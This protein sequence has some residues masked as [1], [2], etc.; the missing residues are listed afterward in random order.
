[1]SKRILKPGMYVKVPDDLVDYSNHLT[2]KKSYKVLS[3][4]YLGINTYF[5]IKNDSNE[6]ILCIL[7][8][9]AFL[10]GGNWVIT[11][12]IIIEPEIYQALLYFLAGVGF[13]YTLFNLIL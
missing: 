5:H 11:S 6:E 3:V 4:E 8:G 7:T 9:C 10:R 13:G 1:M 12:R 2:K